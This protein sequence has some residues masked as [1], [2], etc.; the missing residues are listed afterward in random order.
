MVSNQHATA[1]GSQPVLTLWM[2]MA[3]GVLLLL[4][5]W[6]GDPL[7]LLGLPLLLLIHRGQ[8]PAP[9]P[10]PTPEAG[11]GLAL[12][13]GRL[14]PVWSRQV[15]AADRALQS[16]TEELLESFTQIVEHHQRMPEEPELAET[17]WQQ[18]EKALQGLQFADRLSQMLLVLKRDIDK[19]AVAA[20]ELD[21]AAPADAERW[22][23]DLHDTYTTDEQ[24]VRH[25]GQGPQVVRGKGVDFFD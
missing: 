3:L 14:L 16:G 15:E 9:R 1:Q 12:L 19:L 5:A 17:V 25:E 21:Q 24:R 18:A 7:A 20:P 10:E 4:V 13:L 6:R 2:L 23:Q 11:H 8:A 22:L